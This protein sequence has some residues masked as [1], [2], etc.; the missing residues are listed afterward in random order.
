MR[1]GLLL[2][3]VLVT[4]CSKPPAPSKKAPKFW[5]AAAEDVIGFLDRAWDKAYRDHDGE[6]AD[7][8]VQDCYYA[9]FEPPQR[10]MEAGIKRY[11]SAR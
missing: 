11:I 2:I 6:G 7:R 9:R 3:L 10:N 8:L 1:L 4:S 5:A